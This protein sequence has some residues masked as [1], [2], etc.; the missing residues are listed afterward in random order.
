M[1]SQHYPIQYIYWVS[2]WYNVL[3]R[4]VSGIGYLLGQYLVEQSLDFP[5]LL[6]VCLRSLLHKFLQVVGIL[7]H[8]REK[9]VQDITAITS[10]EKKK[11]KIMEVHA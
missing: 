4:A 8:A 1:V 3:T 6:I 10:K 9:V 11:K 2:I 5:L 7:L